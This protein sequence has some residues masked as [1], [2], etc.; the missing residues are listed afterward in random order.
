M[1]EA[2]Q[3][4]NSTF[5]LKA[6]LRIKALLELEKPVVMETHG[7][8]GK[9]YDR[10]YSHVVD[11][12]V[13]EKRPEKSAKLA[14]QR[15]GWAV[16]ESDCLM[17]LRAGVGSHLPVNFLDLDPYGEPWP[18]MD[19]FFE[20]KRPKPDRLVM[21]VNDGLRQK[22]KMNGGW[23]VGSLQGVVDRMGNGGLYEKYLEVCQ[24]LVKEKAAKAGYVLRRWTGYYAG[25]AGQMTH[26]AAVLVRA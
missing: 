15:P 12:V 1:P 16:Y 23:T 24:A 3:K 11:G 10:C 22:L 19:A 17:A 5:S 20:S 18:V 4:D 2:T 26:Y 25:F 13:F 8:Y 9:L 21:V 7:G 14:K 6:S